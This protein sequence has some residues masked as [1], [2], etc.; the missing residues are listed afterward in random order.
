MK[1]SLLFGN[2]ETQTGSTLKKG[3][4]GG[5]NRGEGDSDL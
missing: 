5:P 1:G 4:G 2:D 3:G